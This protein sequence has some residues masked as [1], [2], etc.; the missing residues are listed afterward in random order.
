MKKKLLMFL[1]SFMFLY[2]SIPGKVFAGAEFENHGPYS[3]VVSYWILN[4]GATDI[5]F[6]LPAR[7]GRYVYNANEWKNK[8]WVIIKKSVLEEGR[9]IV[10][11]GGDAASDILKGTIPIFSSWV[12]KN[13]KLIVHKDGK[14][15]VENK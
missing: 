1:V 11:K 8:K 6:E 4:W 12:G 10:L 3:I 2:L 5:D 13:Q 15:T 14:I 7:G 9:A